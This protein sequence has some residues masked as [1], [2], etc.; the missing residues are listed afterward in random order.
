MSSRT[1]HPCGPSTAARDAV[2][3]LVPDSNWVMYPKPESREPPEVISPYEDLNEMGGLSLCGRLC[4]GLFYRRRDAAR[5]LFG[6][7]KISAL[8]TSRCAISTQK[9]RP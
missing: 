6:D 4:G 1:E 5:A 3:P 9:S 2:E 8:P 7:A